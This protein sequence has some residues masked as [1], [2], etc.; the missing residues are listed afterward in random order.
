MDTLRKDFLT[1]RGINFAF[2]VCI[3]YQ[4]NTL[5]TYVLYYIGMKREA[6]A[7]PN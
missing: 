4:I 2:F 7:L 6:S 5:L 3:S 1:I